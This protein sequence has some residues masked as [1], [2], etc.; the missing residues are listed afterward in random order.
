[1]NSSEESIRQ[2]LLKLILP[3]I[4][5]IVDDVLAPNLDNSKSEFSLADTFKSELSTF[6][7]N[8]LKVDGN[9]YSEQKK[10]L[11][12][13]IPEMFGKIKK[14]NSSKFSKMKSKTKLGAPKKK[15]E[16]FKTSCTFGNKNEFS[17]TMEADIAKFMKLNSNP[18]AVIPMKSPTFET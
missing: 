5:S 18:V 14:S 11:D 13:K 9:P 7:Q 4:I 15:S 1:M 17:K 8:S 16:F 12:T 3:N 2:R 10:K 6:I